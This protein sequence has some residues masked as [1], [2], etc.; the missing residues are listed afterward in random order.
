MPTMTPSRV[1]ELLA[2]EIRDAWWQYLSATQGQLG[3]RYSEIEPW[4]WNRL[5][6]KLRTIEAR[7]RTLKREV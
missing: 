5:Q 3:P 1:D 6:A 4:A 7:R 2:V